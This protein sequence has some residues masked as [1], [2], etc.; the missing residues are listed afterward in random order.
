MHSLNVNL[1]TIKTV[2]PFSKPPFV[3]L[4]CCPLCLP[5][6]VFPYISFVLGV[7]LAVCIIPSSTMLPLPIMWGLCVLGR[8]CSQYLY[9]ILRRNWERQDT[10]SFIDF[11]PVREE[12]LVPTSGVQNRK[13]DKG[14][15]SIVKVQAFSTACG[16]MT[17]EL[18]TA[19]RI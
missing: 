19:L 10:P 13:H 1:D 6:D 18:G 11:L 16:E 9:D 17:P 3:M 14:R 7:C 4:V 8:S 2:V 12:Y 15:F 5:T